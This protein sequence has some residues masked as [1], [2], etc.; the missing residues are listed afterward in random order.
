MLGPK[1]RSGGLMHYRH[2]ILTLCFTTALSLGSGATSLSAG[3]QQASQT[4]PGA[5]PGVTF[6]GVE[7]VIRNV[8]ITFD[9]TVQSAT[10]MPDSWIT[11]VRKGTH[12]ARSG[13]GDYDYT[14]GGSAGTL[15]LAAPV[16]SD[17]AQ[18][19]DLVYYRD[20]GE[21]YEEIARHSG[22]TLPKADVDRDTLSHRSSVHDVFNTAD[23]VN[24]VVNVVRE[25]FY[26]AKIARKTTDLLLRKLEQGSYDGL[27]SSV[28]A[29]RLSKDLMA[30]SADSHYHIS[31]DPTR[32]AYLKSHGAGDLYEPAEVRGA[33]ARENNFGFTRVDIL[34]GNIGY[35]KL[36]EFNGEPKALDKLYAVM[37]FLE[38]CEEIILDFRDNGGGEFPVEEALISYFFPA[39]P[40]LPINEFIFRDPTRNQKNW[41]R[42]DLPGKRLTDQHV[43]I[44]TS[45][46]TYSASESV[47]YRLKVRGRATVVGE[48]SSGGANWVNFFP[49]VDNFVAK[50]PVGKE[51]DAVTKTSWEG[52]GVEVDVSS[53]AADALARAHVLA[54]ERRLK[55]CQGDNC[56]SLQHLHDLKKAM[57]LP[58]V[59]S[60]KHHAG[61]IGRYGSAE[62]AVVDAVLALKVP[63]LSATWFQLHPFKHDI[64][65]L[66]T[67]DGVDGF[68]V[69]FHGSSD[70]RKRLRLSFANGKL[71]EFART[72]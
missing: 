16:P 55:D 30:V 66:E 7:P 43:F 4:E 35:L 58:A 69:T 15:T 12:W 59:L 10:A 72:P 13:D 18:E 32:Y 22:I 60:E 6:S 57:T 45:E 47:A 54:L 11:L 9:F 65:M 1:Y 71:I 25:N 5:R 42:D 20:E 37:A 36:D 34:P 14:L 61:L 19:L 51:I 62:V 48:T 44:L 49:L 8:S 56:S 31:Y 68:H 23:V 40:K 17:G 63:G 39:T 2:A 24:N 50:V 41:T 27:S 64:F 28:L 46:A 21:P 67:P 53:P 52:I 3:T 26:D 33:K 29:S 70:Q 38:D